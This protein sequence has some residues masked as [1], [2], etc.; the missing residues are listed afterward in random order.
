MTS[1]SPQKLTESNGKNFTLCIGY[2]IV[3][4]PGVTCDPI[5]SLSE[6]EAAAN[7]LGLPDTSPQELNIGMSID[8]PF[9]YLDEDDKLWFN[10]DGDN[11]GECDNGDKCIC[12][13]SGK[14]STFAHKLSII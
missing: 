10:G 14:N 6:C 7:Y 1:Q 5:T 4:D 3:E 12:K 8:P 2:T 13:V 11:T 9:C